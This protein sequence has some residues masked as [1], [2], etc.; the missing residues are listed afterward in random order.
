MAGGY[1][2]GLRAQTICSTRMVK[3]SAIVRGASNYGEDSMPDGKS[4]A[5]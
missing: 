4:V 3:E 5:L 2:S 1:I